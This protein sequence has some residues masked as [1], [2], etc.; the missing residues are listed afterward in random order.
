MKTEVIFGNP[1]TGKTYNLIQKINDFRQQGYGKN[2]IQVVSHTRIAA[3]EIVSRS[4]GAFSNTLHSL[5]YSYANITKDQVLSTNEIKEFS[6]KIGIP[7][8]GYSMD[9]TA[10]LEVGDE[11]NGVMNR[12][13][14]LLKEPMDLAHE[15]TE[16][17]NEK[18]YEY[19]VNS[20]QNFKRTYGLIDFNDMLSLAIEALRMTHLKPGFSVFIIDE[21]Q[22]L[23]PLQ[24]LL[25][26][27][28]IEKGD[29]KSAVVTGD[30]DQAIFLW[31]GADRR[32]MENFVSKYSS[33]I[34]E[35]RQS[36]RVP[37]KVHKIS[38][39]IISHA[40]E[41]YV[42]EYE[43]TNKKGHVS[44]STG[45]YALDW[46]ALHGKNVLILY[47]THGFRREFER[48]LVSRAL[49]YRAIAGSPGLFENRLGRAV[50]VFRELQQKPLNVLP[51]QTKVLWQ[52]CLT[53]KGKQLVN[54]LSEFLK[55][56]VE[57]IFVLPN[58]YIEYYRN[59]DFTQTPTIT[60]ST[61]HGA[62][63][64]EADNVI[65]SKGITNRILNTLETYP[66]DEYKVWFVGV[67]RA[68]ENLTLV[69]SEGLD[70]DL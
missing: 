59:T 47:R 46:D 21:A 38:A 54:N 34:K 60:L 13:R 14:A 45:A 28:I 6:E 66:G 9:D 64:M 2:E 55:Q 53:H 24:W 61:I 5:A 68:K 11:Y 30:P 18:E 29:I 1:G 19:F 7:M 16:I 12:A 51:A 49:P 48:E 15:L 50:K 17:G 10:T 62:K 65:V 31:G 33:E 39:D 36:Y 58:W 41:R 35:L 23:S 63:G 32:G 4:E 67:T 40:Q 37:E 44:F 43:P 56:K 3:A 57:D 27:T 20:Y 26:D 25:I 8:K 69:N 52:S 22:D 70:I 42:K